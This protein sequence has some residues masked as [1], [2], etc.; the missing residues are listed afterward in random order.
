MKT[1]IIGLGN[2]SFSDDGVGPLVARAIKGR[3]LPR[4]VT[5]VEAS[6]AGLDILD[7][8]DDYRKAVIIDAVQTRNAPPGAIHRF[9][10]NRL[11]PAAESCPHNFDLLAAF[12]LGKRLGIPLP[13]EVIVYG[14]EVRNF[15]GP[16]EA[17]SPPVRAAVPLCAEQILAELESEQDIGKPPR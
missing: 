14:I 9:N 13:R 16:G 8:V 7:I 10:I 6:A 4:D 5:V 1:I 12:E 15:D 3:A 17:I 11:S 2:P